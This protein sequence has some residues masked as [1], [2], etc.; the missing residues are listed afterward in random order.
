MSCLPPRNAGC[1]NAIGSD[2][3]FVLDNSGSIGTSNFDSVKQFVRDVVNGFEVGP[4]KTRFGV[5]KFG[6]DF[7]H[8]VDFCF[9]S[10]KQ[11]LL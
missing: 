2:I 6:S 8:P 9:R 1:Q 11:L 3:I 7:K 5:V 10:T 4:D